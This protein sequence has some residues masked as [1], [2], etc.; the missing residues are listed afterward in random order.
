MPG[1]GA[2][3]HLAALSALLLACACA[4]PQNEGGGYLVVTT[5]IT[6]GGSDRRAR[7][8]N[9]LMAAL[10]RCHGQ[11]YVDAQRAGPPETHCLENGPDGCQRFS[12][13]INWDCIGMGYQPN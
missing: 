3:R 7:E 1:S 2:F 8:W 11:G 12:A 4:G 6:Y 5:D 13:H 9:A 10:D